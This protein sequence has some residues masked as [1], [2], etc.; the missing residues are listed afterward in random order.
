MM[1]CVI[2][3]LSE[4]SQLFGEKFSYDSEEVQILSQLERQFGEVLQIDSDAPELLFNPYGGLLLKLPL[5][6]YARKKRQIKEL[7]ETRDESFLPIVQRYR[8]CY[9][10]QKS[11]HGC[12]NNWRDWKIENNS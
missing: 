5:S 10:K 6:R 9:C 3:S 12:L 1:L 8:V 4:F 2:L 7:L 11:S